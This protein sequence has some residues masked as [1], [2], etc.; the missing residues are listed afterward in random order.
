MAS[1]IGQ[2]ISHLSSD[3]KWEIF[4]EPNYDIQGDA[5]QHQN[6]KNNTTFQLHRDWP[7]NSMRLST[8]VIEIGLQTQCY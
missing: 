8:K 1:A 3:D 7:S 5:R 6:K 4:Y 2:A